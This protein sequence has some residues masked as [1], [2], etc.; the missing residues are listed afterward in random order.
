[1][2][3]GQLGSKPKIIF[4][5]V[6]TFGLVARAF[7]VTIAFRSVVSRGPVIEGLSGIYEVHHSI[8]LTHWYIPQCGELIKYTNSCTILQ[9][10]VC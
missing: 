8:N 9:F 6:H 4:S 5:I 10:T 3:Y 7:G 2:P 1:M